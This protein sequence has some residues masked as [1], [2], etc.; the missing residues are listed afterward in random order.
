MAK[1]LGKQA[2]FEYFNN[3]SNN[4]SHL[5]DTETGFIRP[6]IR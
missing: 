5:F 3:R 6:E 1:L 4:W 2:D